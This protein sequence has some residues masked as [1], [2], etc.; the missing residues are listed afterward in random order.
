MVGQTQLLI[1]GVA[2]Q[3]EQAIQ[4]PQPR[5]LAVAGTVSPF[6]QEP[7]EPK[8]KV[9]GYTKPY[10]EKRGVYCSCVSFLRAAGIN[11]PR[12]GNGTASTSPSNREVPA[13]GAIVLARA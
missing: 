9:G 13:V 10:S 8:N 2:H 5:I 6:T 11:F 7:P 3:L 1:P 12:T 4:E